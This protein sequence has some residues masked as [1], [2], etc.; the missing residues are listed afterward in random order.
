MIKPNA[1]IFQ[2]ILTRL[3]VTPHEAI[4]LMTMRIIQEVRKPSASKA[5]FS[6]I[7]LI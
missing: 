3:D 6:Q 7:L 4:L 2:L 5:C 1:D